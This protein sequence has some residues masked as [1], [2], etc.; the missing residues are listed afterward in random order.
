MTSYVNI[1]FPT[2]QLPS[3]RW[4]KIDMGLQAW[5]NQPY[6]MGS[7]VAMT[8][9]P[10]AADGIPAIFDDAPADAGFLSLDA[11]EFEFH[12]TPIKPATDDTT[13]FDVIRQGTPPLHVWHIRVWVSAGSTETYATAPTFWGIVDSAEPTGELPIWGDRTYWTIRMRARNQLAYLE[14]VTVDYWLNGPN[15]NDGY[16][17]HA[18]YDYV[19]DYTLVDGYQLHQI[20]HND[21]G[22]ANWE[23]A[24]TLRYFRLRDVIYSIGAA[25]GVTRPINDT[26]TGTGTVGHSWEYIWIDSPDPG[27]TETPVTFDDLAIVSAMYRSDGNQ[28]V[29]DQSQSF[30]DP[31]KLNQVSLW[32]FSNALEVIRYLLTPFGLQ[33]RVAVN[34]SGQ[35]YLEIREAEIDEEAALGSMLVGMTIEEA[36]TAAFGFRVVTANNGEISDGSSE[37]GSVDNPFIGASR[38]RLDQRF[39]DSAPHLPPLTRST[40]DEEALYQALWAIANVGG[41]DVAWSIFKVGVKRDGS[42][43]ETTRPGTEPGNGSVC[44]P[45]ITTREEAGSVMAKACLAY[46]WNGTADPADDPVG[47]Y[48]RTMMRMTWREAGLGLTARTGMYKT[49]GGEKWT[50]RRI[51][52]DLVKD[53][54]EY[55]AERGVIYA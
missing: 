29:F 53:E 14:Y 1:I 27:P 45:Q 37:G 3:G 55:S 47:I 44:Y 51:A 25:M 11:I 48:R 21:G 16:L 2:F 30:F 23:L 42:A 39:I 33:A 9:A 5:G 46:Y 13:L 19:P 7:Q 24:S 17:Q 26:G 15:G 36:D 18:T 50:L 4:V 34:A 52:V 10:W 54:T 40:G 8:V 38:M 35:R 22:S 43:G 12:N 20:M 32:Q 31:L 6:G 41:D 49:I 28:M